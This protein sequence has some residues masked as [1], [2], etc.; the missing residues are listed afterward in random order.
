[1]RKVREKSGVERFHA[2]LCRH[3][4]G[5]WALEQGAERAAVQDMLGHKSDAMTVHYT[6]QARLKTAAE[7]MPKYSPV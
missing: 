1:M 4:F 6:K 3:T 2:H 5:Q 7:M